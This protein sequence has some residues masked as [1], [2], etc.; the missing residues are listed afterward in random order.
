ME[1]FAK[2]ALVA[3]VAFSFWSVFALGRQPQAQSSQAQDQ[4]QQQA[5]KPPH[6]DTEPQPAARELENTIM[7]ALKQDPHMAY[8]RVRV[9]VT[10]TEVLLTGVV[11][12][13][14]AKDQAAQI[15][16]DHAGGRK[17][18]NHIKVNPSTHP[19]PGI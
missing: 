11:L 8:S 2:S 6:T 12:T 5:E 19:A 4:A 7:D 16:T 10:D 17:V 9:H 1:R 13:A 3:V 15:A 14:T 18:V